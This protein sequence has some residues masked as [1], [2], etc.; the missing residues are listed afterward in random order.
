[1]EKHEAKQILQAYRTDLSEIDDPKVGEALRMAK[2][3]PELNA[4]LDQEQAF[5]RAF[6]QKLKEIEPPAGLL[7]RILESAPSEV[8]AMPRQGKPA[9]IIWWKNPV[10]WSAAA[11]V[12]ALIALAAVFTQNRAPSTNES[13][14]VVMNNFAQAAAQHSPTIHQ[15]DFQHSDVS[16]IGAY[17]DRN[18]SP[19]PHSLPDNMSQLLGMGCVTYT[20]ENNPV[21]V[22]CLKGEKVYNLYVTH[23]GGLAIERSQSSPYYKQFGEYSTALWT[24]DNLIYVLTVEGQPEDLSPLL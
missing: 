19:R 2:E 9:K 18:N 7:E 16:L 8:E 21:G 14:W 10:V 4:Y 12:L 5:D 11:C 15:M 24:K 6:T 23:R 20:W 13:D 17:L 3:N 1:M 22:I